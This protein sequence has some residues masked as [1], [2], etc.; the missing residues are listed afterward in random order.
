MHFSS[1]TSAGQADRY[2][3][4]S[5]P[6]TSSPS[7]RTLIHRVSQPRVA[8]HHNPGVGGVKCKVWCKCR[9]ERPARAGIGKGSAGKLQRG[10]ASEK[11]IVDQDGVCGKGKT[12]ALTECS[13]THHV[14]TAALGCPH[15][16]SGDSR[17]SGT[18]A[19]W[20][21]D[22]GKNAHKIRSA[23]NSRELWDARTALPQ[24]CSRKRYVPVAR[25]YIPL[26][27]QSHGTNRPYGAPRAAS[28]AIPQIVPT[29]SGPAPRF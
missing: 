14:G 21:Q 3:G 20:N 10:F 9:R 4:N 18:L 19:P 7:L 1:S 11:T 8:A 25:V 29:Q 13:L 15:V 16:A 26:S 23:P 6:G 12:P 22:R 5:K 27:C 24:V 17:I 2:P 28:A